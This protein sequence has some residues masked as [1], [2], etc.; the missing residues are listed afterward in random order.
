MRGGAGKWVRLKVGEQEDRMERGWVL[1]APAAALAKGGRAGL[2]G[3]AFAGQHAAL[4]GGPTQPRSD[5]RA[6]ALTHI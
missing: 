1:G 6:I 2:I 4:V 5:R 3:G